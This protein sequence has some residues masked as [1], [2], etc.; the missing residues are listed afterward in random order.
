MTASIAELPPSSSAPAWCG[1]SSSRRTSGST[2]ATFTSWATSAIRSAEHRTAH[3]NTRFPSVPSVRS[4]RDC[5]PSPRSPAGRTSSCRVLTAF[6][7]WR[8]H[9][10]HHTART[11]LQPEPRPASAHAGP[12]AHEHLLDLELSLGIPTRSRRDGQSVLHD[13][14]SAPGDL[15][16]L[17]DPGVGR[18]ALPPRHRGHFGAVPPFDVALPG[19]GRRG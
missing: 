11:H 5:P 3:W 2:I 16:E 14:R 12:S 19:T 18:G 10:E 8:G 1:S 4:S 7:T 13:D 6:D 17:R 9:H 15:A